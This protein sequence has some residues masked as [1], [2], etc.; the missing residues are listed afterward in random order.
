[1]LGFERHDVSDLEMLFLEI[2]W[3][4]VNM[5]SSATISVPALVTIFQ[6]WGISRWKWETL[7]S[8][9]YFQK[10]DG[11]DLVGLVWDV[12]LVIFYSPYS[13]TSLFLEEI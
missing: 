5:L 11:S 7:I 10:Y 8:C 1:M 4:I 13:S 6:G 9:V 3:V 2:D 12:D